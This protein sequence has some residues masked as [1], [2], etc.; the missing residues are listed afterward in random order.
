MNAVIQCLSS[1]S[2]LVEYFFSWQFENLTARKKKTF[3]NAFAKLVVDL[4]FGESQ[5]VTP[6]DFWDA[7]CCVHPPFGKISQQDAQELLIYT[8]NGLH[9]DLTKT[10]NN[11][12]SNMVQGIIIRHTI[13]SASNTPITRFF[14]GVLS[15]TII[16][17]ECR[18]R[19]YKE[20]IFTV[21]SI[22][23]PSGNK[24]SLMQCLQCFFQ[25]VML[26]STDRIF[27]SYCKTKQ[28]ATVEVKIS[29]PPKILILH[30]KRFEHQG[31]VRRKL[32]TNVTFP[33][34]NLDMSPFVTL[35]NV[36]L[37]EFHLYS[38]VVSIIV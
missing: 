28:D 1:T 37:S 3:V 22:P 15:Q 36:T 26:T 6:E 31:R 30:L 9:E 33:L 29:K 38:V 2:P 12:S 17:M 13:R 35:Y 23:I 19:S 5:S 20:D 18:R 11:K 34:T 14:Q 21:L 16:C 32:K 27:C 7:L 8:L 10:I 24:A 4:W 25:Q